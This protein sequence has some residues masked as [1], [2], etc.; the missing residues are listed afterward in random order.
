MDAVTE[1]V[2]VYDDPG[3]HFVTDLYKNRPNWFVY[4]IYRLAI[5][6]AN[7]RVKNLRSNPD[8]YCGNSE[9]CSN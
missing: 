8:S 3:E 9:C 5:M 4:V 6:I 1:D 2:G 7:R